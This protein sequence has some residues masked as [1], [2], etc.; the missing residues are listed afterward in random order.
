[1]VE[2]KKA[3][4]APRLTR[5]KSAR[6]NQKT[7]LDLFPRKRSPGQPPDDPK[8]GAGE[9]STTDNVAPTV[10]DH[11]RVALPTTSP[12]TIA[13]DT[14]HKAVVNVAFEPQTERLHPIFTKPRSV[15][16]T[17][18]QIDVLLNTIIE[19]Q[20]DES[21]PDTMESP[22]TTIPPDSSE[23]ASS[24]PPS[25]CGEGSTRHDP[26]IIESSP[27]KPMTVT[28]PEVPKKLYSLF[29]ARPTHPPPNTRK[30]KSQTNIGAPYPTDSNTHIRGPQSL[31]KCPPIPYP[32][33]TAVRVGGSIQET[34][35][36]T[37][38]NYSYG[39]NPSVGNLGLHTLPS[40][41]A[42][43]REI[44]LK[45]IP[46][47][48]KRLHP[49]I[50]RILD[51]PSNLSSLNRPWAQKWHPTRAIE[52]LGNELNALYLRDWL[53]ALELQIHQV[54]TTSGGIGGS[55]ANSQGTANSK[56]PV[57]GTKR[58][59]VTRA[60]SKKRRNKKSRF[61]TE[62]D[63][64]DNWIVCDEEIDDFFIDEEVE[65][66][67]DGFDTPPP[68]SSSK[69]SQNFLND[70]LKNTILLAG[71]PGTG[72]TA[73]IYACAEE[74]GWDIFEVYPG[75]GRR[76]GA[77]IEHLVGEVGKN[78]MVGKS[79][80]KG[81]TIRIS[82]RPVG[83]HEAGN[84]DGETDRWNDIADL[85]PEDTQ[86][87]GD[88]GFL[89]PTS[90][91]PDD[92]TD[93]STPTIRQ[94][95]ILL[96]EV[97]ILF[98]DDVNFWPA[99]INFIR[100]CKRPV[101]C[102]CNDLALVPTLDLPLQTTLMFQPCESGIAASYLQ[103]LCSAEGRMIERD[104]LV[105]LYQST[106]DVDSFN[107]TDTPSPVDGRVPDLRKTIHA[108]QLGGSDITSPLMDSAES[109]VDL[110]PGEDLE[111]S[112]YEP[113]NDANGRASGARHAELVSFAD[114]YLTRAP[115]DSQE[116]LILDS[117]EPSV[118]DEIG[119]TILY[120]PGRGKGRIE[121]GFGW[122][123]RDDEIA[124]SAIRLSRG[125]L[126]AG[127][128]RGPRSINTVNRNSFGARALFRARV[129]YQE[130]MGPFLLRNV[131]L[132]G[133]LLARTAVHL[134][135][136]PFIRQIVAADDE[137]EQK[138]MEMAGSRGGR[139]TRN[140]QLQRYV[141]TIDVSTAERDILRATLFGDGD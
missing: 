109:K 129:E 74:L 3:S 36:N 117:Y 110:G 16:H 20:D 63:A 80:P 81:D 136:G 104:N 124:S 13:G 101:V 48:H 43:N 135:Y 25:P 10:D 99:V 50:T 141:R 5:S 133:R 88:F 40:T 42:G 122:C 103:G 132:S 75:I 77:N 56:K 131:G 47:E 115:L 52:V 49:A 120:K 106:I 130:H 140:S 91:Q 2:K 7:I 139:M 72:K 108:L 57:R 118:D 90:I 134:E 60:V 95:L 123:D 61:G 107:V 17:S 94:S 121:Y 73:S 98:K 84:E 97:D 111:W 83:A 18:S 22:L 39:N 62:D 78:H 9:M 68:L 70:Q 11:M 33:R 102:T 27:V 26:I 93:V 6:T 92:K 32:R 45:D 137:Q 85:D 55:K 4:T 66:T 112:W 82:Q 53:R 138:Y 21:I 1:M 35:P 28:N 128:T 69:L 119:H 54:P 86:P 127:E 51:P 58:P 8:D 30:P 38:I 12:P 65:I 31:F 76:N 34:G 87:S 23:A 126:E 79:G 19:I 41:G 44:Y 46:E 100:D 89:S 14:S 59:H 24:R 113:Q 67:N 37:F 29:A 96:E 71:P 125:T 114:S 116:A 105:Q 15:A 64:N